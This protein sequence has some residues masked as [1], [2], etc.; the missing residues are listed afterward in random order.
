MLERKKDIGSV[1]REINVHI[2]REQLTYVTHKLL[3]FPPPFLTAQRRQVE[4]I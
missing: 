4:I 1:H 2:G 3:T